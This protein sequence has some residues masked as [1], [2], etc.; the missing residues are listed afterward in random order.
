MKDL[1]Q[2]SNIWANSTNDQAFVF[3][4]TQSA[5]PHKHV[6]STNL[7]AFISKQNFVSYVSKVYY[8]DTSSAIGHILLA[9]SKS[10]QIYPPLSTS[11]DLYTKL[12][13]FTHLTSLN[14][15]HSLKDSLNSASSYFLALELHPSFYRW[16][17][18]DS[19][20]KRQ[21]QVIS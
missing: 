5:D 18:C 15:H 19:D 2:V 9:S 1:R 3:T 8:S 11:K 20:K 4:G 13:V 16:G 14:P 12:S 6:F 17:N 10:N 7:W 21:C